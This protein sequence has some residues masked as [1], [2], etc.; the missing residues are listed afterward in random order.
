VQTD[1]TGVTII[2]YYTLSLMSIKE[3]SE[4]SVSCGMDDRLL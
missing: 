2:S 4:A 1:T 3:M